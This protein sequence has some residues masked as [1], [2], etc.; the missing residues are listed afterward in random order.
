[1]RA[2]DMLFILLWIS[3]GALLF[4]CSRSTTPTQVTLDGKP[5]EFQVARF[6]GANILRLEGMTLRLREPY[7]RLDFVG[8]ADPPPPPCFWKTV[9]G[10]STQFHCSR[11]RKHIDD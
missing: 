8:K 5:V 1:M 9:L 3:L 6:A 7:T 10:V 11:V 2:R 4:H